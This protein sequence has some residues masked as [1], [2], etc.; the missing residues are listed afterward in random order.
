MRPVR[1]RSLLPVG[2]ALLAAAPSPA[3]RTRVFTFDYAATVPALPAGA[4]SLELWLPV[5]HPDASQ[6]IRN[7]KITASA[8][9]K[10]AAAPYG[11]QVLHLKVSASQAANLR[12]AMRFEATRREHLN[13]FLSPSKE[14]KVRNTRSIEPTDPDMARWLAPDRLVPLDAKIKTWAQEVV[15]KAGAKTDLEK[16]RA[17]YEHVVSTVTYDKTGQGWGRGDIYY[18][19]DARRGNCTDFHAVFIG[20]CRALGIPARF[21]IGFPL[22]AERGAGEIK[23]YHCWA[24]FYTKQTGWVP[25]DASEAAKDPSRRAYFFGAH[26]ENRVEF[27]RGRDVPLRPSQQGQP[28]NYFIYP[29]AEVD[30]K[31]FD[32]VTREFRY[33][34]LGQ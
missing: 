20:Y 29:Y 13:P 1:F 22:P 17:I 8:P 12:V 16:A 31:P 27:T 32:G 7:L 26:D 34:D 18:A 30:G 6:D 19:C 25:V 5:P 33:Q 2:F 14:A 15:A 24:E 10:L 3:P 11:N 28:L 9:Y 21:S 23:G 4:D